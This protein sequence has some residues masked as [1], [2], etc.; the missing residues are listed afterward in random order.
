MARDQAIEIA[1]PARAL[2]VS[3]RRRPPCCEGVRREGCDL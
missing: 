2:R 1:E 3:V